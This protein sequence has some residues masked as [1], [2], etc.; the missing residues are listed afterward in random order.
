MAYDFT[1]LR[2][3]QKQLS[4][5]IGLVKVHLNI[6]VKHNDYAI[7]VLNWSEAAADKLVSNYQM[8]RFEGYSETTQN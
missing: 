1:K 6:L 5:I 2:A 3:S 8:T 4:F 7:I